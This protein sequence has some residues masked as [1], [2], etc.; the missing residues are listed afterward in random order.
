[1]SL[2]MLKDFYAANPLLKFRLLALEVYGR[3]FVRHEDYRHI[4][5]E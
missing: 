5:I 3:I 4:H 2:R 1:M